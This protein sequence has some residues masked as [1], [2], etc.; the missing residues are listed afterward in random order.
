M[1]HSLLNKW[2]HDSLKIMN[3]Q[4]VP[5][6]MDVQVLEATHKWGMFYC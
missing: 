5:S 4:M 1:E 6:T 2:G 3:L